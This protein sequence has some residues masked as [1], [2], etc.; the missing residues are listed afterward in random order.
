M[1][2]RRPVS[3]A[4]QA[5]PARAF[6]R[7]AIVLSI[8]TT[9]A[10][11][12]ALWAPRP[13]HADAGRDLAL[14][15]D[16]DAALDLDAA[17][18]TT[19]ARPVDLDDIGGG[20][21]LWKRKSGLVPL[22]NVG[23]EVAIDIHGPLI[24]GRVVQRFRNPTD[25]IIDAL[26]VFP[27]PEGAAVDAMEM[28]IGDRLIVSVV[29]EKVEARRTY[30]KA[31]AEGRRAALVES[32]RPNLFTTSVANICPGETVEV[33]LEYLD[34]AEF[35]SGG[36][37]MTFPLTFTPRYVPPHLMPRLDGGP[38]ASPAAW[39]DLAS[40][41]R[42]A[43]PRWEQPVAV[44]P[45][46]AV[47]VRIDAGAPIGQVICPSHGVIARRD[48]DRDDRAGLTAALTADRDFRLEWAVDN[49]E[50]AAAC[51]VEDRPDGRYAMV[52]LLP[53]VPEPGFGPP[54]DT[55][56][57]IDV[58]GSM[59]GESIRQARV[60][61]INALDRLRPGDRFDILAFNNDSRFFGGGLAAADAATV[62]R[63]RTWV[64]ALEADGGTMMQPAVLRAGARF[65]GAGDGDGPVARDASR[66]IVVI[67]DA[68]IG[69]EDQLLRDAIAGF[70]D[71]RVHMVGIGYAPNRYLV[72]RMAALG[73]GLSTF[74]AD[75][76]STAA[77]VDGFMRRIDRPVLYDLALEWDGDPA[78]DGQ[79]GKLTELFAGELLLWSGRFPAGAD[80]RGRITG[81][82]D[83]GAWSC[84]IDDA[85]AAPG[86]GARWARLAIDDLM[87][88]MYGG[89]SRDVVRGRVV[90]IALDHG[91]VTEF[92]SRVAVE[93][94]PPAGSAAMRCGLQPDS[95]QDLLAGV[96]RAGTTRRLA[97]LLGALLAA[98]GA[99]GLVWLRAGGAR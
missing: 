51:F 88:D 46:V 64:A 69:D 56:F 38:E 34:N 29:K 66:R 98:L 6:R 53:D 73:G 37:R 89:A 99:A 21:L 54:T 4:A 85:V 42:I 25:G 18:R 65:L 95:D 3:I 67:T 48:A 8:L 62:A 52:M 16:P 47:A 61:L 45:Q 1:H 35:D 93:E 49:D 11:A 70:G 9:L 96:P 13:A 79:A 76:D 22:P 28:I 26:Y 24:S 33:V 83:Q 94:S 68:A 55:V 91:L 82:G 74:V 87:A 75:L 2:H 50:P 31:R 72:D 20:E 63:A 40:L 36:F 15:L 14:A 5:D 57:V 10:I 60:A 71:V 32:E 86:T 17:F 23:T 81:R 92:T 39:A 80:V 30:E 44:H 7:K 41:L 84:A 27:L 78:I 12:T 19:A 90:D 59:E 97:M 77:V 58:S 43:T